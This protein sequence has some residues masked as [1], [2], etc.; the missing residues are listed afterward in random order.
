MEESELEFA[1]SSSTRSEPLHPIDSV[2]KDLTLAAKVLDRSRQAISVFASMLGEYCACLTR[3]KAQVDYQG[4][5]QEHFT[6]PVRFKR[7]VLTTKASAQATTPVEYEEDQPLDDPVDDID[8]SECGATRQHLSTGGTRNDCD[9]RTMSS[10]DDVSAVTVD[11]RIVEKTRRIEEERK[12]RK[13]KGPVYK[14]MMA[15]G[16]RG[17][18]FSRYDDEADEPAKESPPPMQ[19]IF[20]LEEFSVFAH[21]PVVSERD[22]WKGTVTIQSQ[23]HWDKA[24]FERNRPPFTVPFFKKDGR[25]AFL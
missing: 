8:P 18:H 21:F 11:S 14:C 24:D 25:S 3:T 12:A 19:N 13:A 6:P 7:T 17:Q 5:K 10:I 20:G 4:I 16:A 2:V 22:V 1:L 9:T 23:P 15:P